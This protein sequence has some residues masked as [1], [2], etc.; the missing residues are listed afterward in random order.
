MPGLGQTI[1]EIQREAAVLPTAALRAEI[2][3]NLEVQDAAIHQ[4]ASIRPGTKSAADLL[5]ATS[6][7]WFS[8]LTTALYVAELATRPAPVTTIVPSVN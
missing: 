8:V 3:F 6:A 1:R 2:Q 5:T 7:V 4:L